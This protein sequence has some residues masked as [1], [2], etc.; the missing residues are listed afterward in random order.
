[1]AISKKVSELRLRTN[2]SGLEQT[3]VVADGEN[4]RV[5]L[6]TIKSLVSKT[7]LG[8][9][10]VN[11]TSDLEKPISLLVS[12]ALGGKAPVVHTHS[13]SDVTGLTAYITSE[14]DRLASTLA[15]ANHTHQISDIIDLVNSLSNKASVA[16]LNTLA[17]TISNINAA[18]MGKANSS[19]IHEVTDINN[20]LPTIDSRIT[21]KSNVGH[22]HDATTITGLTSFIQNILVNVVAGFSSVGHTHGLTDVL[23]LTDA[24]AVKA[25]AVD[26][27][28]LS[29]LITAT[30]LSL[31]TKSSVGH[32]HS[33]YDILNFATEVRAIITSMA[34][35]PLNHSHTSSQIT[36]L[37]SAVQAVVRNMS[38]FVSNGVYEVLPHGHN[39]AQINDLIPTILAQLTQ[40]NL[41]SVVQNIVNSMGL[42]NNL[43]YATTGILE[44]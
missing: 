30:Q 11:N 8:L 10:R 22:T 13:V 41:Q 7:D 31:G 37:Q 20:L 29:T 9:D 44:W 18:L 26:V 6:N 5:T 28:A 38:Y 12:T 24:L 1:M 14:L 25:N 33:I 3:F 2:P 23:G 32:S 27:T 17:S 35:A 34:L 36:D 16:D 40:V 42:S 19:H 15:T 21:N 39:A 43:N 4:Y